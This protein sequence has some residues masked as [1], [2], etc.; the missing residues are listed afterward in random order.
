MK[1]LIIILIITPT[2]L[3]SQTWEKTYDNGRGDQGHSVEQTNDGGYIVTGSTII[4][5]DSMGFHFQ[6]YIIKT[7]NNGDTLWT[8]IYGGEDWD[9]GNSIQQTTDGGFIITGATYSLQ[10]QTG[11]VYLIKTDE[12]GDSLWTRTYGGVYVDVGRSVKQTTDD[13]FIITGYTRSSGTGSS[14]VYLIKTD[15]NG[16]TLWTKTFGG[17]EDDK[18]WSVQQTNDGGYIITGYTLSFGVSYYYD[19]YLIKTDSNGDSLWTK[20]FNG[21][22]SDMGY[23]VEQTTDGGYIISGVTWSSGYGN[24]DVYLIK[25][26]CNGDTLWTKTFGGVAHESGLTSVQQTIDGGYIVTGTTTS[27][28]NG[29]EDVFL[30]K[31]DSDGNTL[32][33][34][35]FGGTGDDC[36]ISVQQ[37]TD[38]GYIIT[39][40]TWSFGTYYDDVYLIKTDENGIVTS[41]IEIPIPNS[42]RKLIKTIDILG[43]EITTPNKN[44]SYI[45][46]YDNG[47]TK[48]KIV[49]K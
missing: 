42:N 39:G 27:F 12:N 6:V 43:K 16:D 17:E 14:E 41:T 32:W 40:Y 34:R 3:F 19:V 33:T 47:T 4:W 45:E 28:G 20:V 36:G 15:S 25:T 2:F 22:S 9:W 30:I 38:G 13:G 37:T 21:G 46:I 29:N 48:K 18:G 8:K 31:T 10:T 1:Y 11:D 5:S 7:D 24:D 49:I 44:Q 26:D 35:T 23:S